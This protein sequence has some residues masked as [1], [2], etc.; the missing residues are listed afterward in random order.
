[1]EQY[2]VKR[3]LGRGG[4]GEVYEVVDKTTGKE[5]AMKRIDISE[6]EPEEYEKEASLLKALSKLS[7][8]NIVKYETS[9]PNEAEEEYIII[10]EYCK[11]KLQFLLQIR[12]Q[13]ERDDQRI[14][15]EECE[16][17]RGQ[18]NGATYWNAA[19]HPIHTC[20]RYNTQRSQAGKHTA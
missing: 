15:E 14:Q 3:K 6:K 7:H 4:F 12:R 5:Y 19:R 10:M 13:L 18:N 16:N 8:A 17:P 11:G 2:C 1:M 20:Q 9:F